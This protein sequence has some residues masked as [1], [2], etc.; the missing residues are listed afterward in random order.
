MGKISVYLALVLLCAIFSIPALSQ[1]DPA[2]QLPT[3]YIRYVNPFIGTGGHGHTYP[4]ATAPFGL[5][6]LSPDTRIDMMDWDGCSGYHYSDTKVYGFSHTH[7]SGTGV[8]DYGDILF[9]PYVGDVALE[10]ADYASDFNK[11]QEK[12]AA[13]YY[14][15]LLE[16][17]KILAELT[18][19]EHVGVHRYTFPK[20]KESG[21]LL[22]DLRHRDEVLNAHLEVVSN[23]EIAGYRI[24]KAWAKEQHVYFVARFSRPFFNTVILDMTKDPRESQ[25]SLTGQS[26]VALLDFYQD[27]EPLVVTVGISGVSMEGARRNLE[28]ECNSFDFDKTRAQTH[29]KWQRQL[30]KIEVESD[31]EEQK[32]IF[33][34]ALYHTMIAPNIWNDV[35]GQ[36]RGRDNNIHQA[37]GHDVYTVF[38]L[39]DTY[40]AC[41]PLY[42]IL[43]PKRT[44]DFIQTFLLQY[45]QG[46]LMPV[47]ELS[48]NE[49]D[50]MIGNHAIPVITDAYQK[51]IRDFDVTKALQAMEASVSQKRLGQEQ[52]RANGFISSDQ[53]SESVSKTLEYAYDDWCI[54]QLGRASGA[55]DYFKKYNLRSQQYKNLFDPS[56]KF[57]LAR[58]HGAWYSPF[59]PFEVNF[60]YTEANAWQYRFAA[61]QDISGLMRLMGGRE[62]FAAQL[63]TLFSV[64][65]ALSGRNQSDITGL[66]GQYVHGNEPS[67]HMAYLYNYAGQPWKTQQRVRQILDEMYHNRPDGLSGNEDCGQMSAWNVLSAMGFYPVTPGDPTYA[68]GSPLFDKVRIHLDNG[69]TCIIAAPGASTQKCYFKRLTYNGKEWSKT[70]IGHDMILEGGNFDFEMSDEPS[71]WGSG[72]HDC[73]VSAIMGEE[74]LPVPFIAQGKRVFRG[75]QRIALGCIDAGAEIWYQFSKGSAKPENASSSATRYTGPFNIKKGGDLHIWSQKNGVKSLVNTA[76]FSKIIDDLY[77]LRYNMPYNAQY[78]AC[79]QEGLIDGIRGCK[80]DFRTGDWQGFEG[81][82]LDFVIDLG[83]SKKINSVT[84]GFLQDENAWIFFPSKMRVEISEDGKNFELAGEVLSSKAPTEKGVLQED[85]TVRLNDKKGRYVRV[86]GVSMGQ[87]P[88][89][90]KGKGYPSWVFVDEVR[91]E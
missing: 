38:S 28:A 1:S 19:S 6:Q 8:A 78:S 73:P 41:N 72:E 90:H 9:M 20:N 13:G 17:G 88:E 70:W 10:P 31:N 42:T 40:R 33:Y 69:K 16:K 62:A 75:Q 2:P 81:N 27:G 14:S 21:S 51:G 86:V 64:K 87:C 57:F 76:S 50:C 89:W 7:L 49:T 71:K 61:P 25:P 15:V 48:A 82:N 4:G 67:H 91:V 59:D 60:N 77:V 68:L 43:E 53:E 56:S 30:S 83:K 47:W 66:I 22:V 39:W 52:Y 35:D 12:A 85:F 63:D 3:N 24:S 23:Q 79:G 11:S 80:T 54:G 58:N 46:G 44:N 45:E 84:G 26:M 5:V 18:A 36:Y 65:Q 74:I 37:S 32:T 34:T 55:P 29:A